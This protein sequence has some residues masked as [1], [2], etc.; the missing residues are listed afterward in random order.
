MSR[1]EHGRAGGRRSGEAYDL[2]VIGGGPAGLAAAVAASRAG[3]TVALIDGG[4]RLGG[5]YYRHPPPGL[6]PSHP[7]TSQHGFARFERLRAALDGRVD[8]LLRHQSWA[9]ERIGGDAS[10]WRDLRGETFAVRCLAGER[11]ETPETVVARRLVIATGAHDLPL[12]FPGWDLPGVMTAGGAQA[13]LKGNLVLAGRRV[14]VAGTGPFL[15]PVAAGLAGAGA[16]VAGVFEANGGL[17]IAPEL[18]RRPGKVAEASRYGYQL[19]RHGTPYRTRHAVIAAHGDRELTHVTVAAIDENWRPRPGRRRTIACDALAVGYGFTPRLDLAVQLGCATGPDGS[20]GVVV[21]VDAGMRTSVPGVYAAGETTGVG[22]ADLAETEGW[23]AGRAVAADL[24]R[25][26]RPAPALSRRRDRQ[27]AFAR[28]LRRAYPIK[29]GWT[30][31]LDDDTLICRCEEVPYARVR[32]ARD[33]GA[34]DARAIKLLARPGMGWCQGR[35][36]GYAVSRLA[37]EDL[38]PPRRLI[39]QPIRLG[40][41]AGLELEPPSSDQRSFDPDTSGLRPPER[42]QTELR[43]PGSEPAQ[44]RHAPPRFDERSH[45]EPRSRPDET[46]SSPAQSPERRQT[47]PQVPGSEPAQGRH[48]PPRFDER[49]HVEPRSRPDETRSSP[50]QSP[51]RRQTEPQVPGSEP[52]QGRHAPPR[53]DERSHVEPRSRP[54]ETRSSPA[55]SPERRQT[56]LRVPGSEPAQGRHAPPRFD[57][58][59]HVEPRSRPDETRSSPAQSPERRQTELR[60]PGSEPAQG[61]HAPP[62]FDER[63]HV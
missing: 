63:S 1:R 55:Q 58:R 4:P 8:V 38:A 42:R 10:S 26:L 35:M 51:E 40:D 45:V 36:C 60:V 43:V 41:L 9:V 7:G 13:L 2:A 20:G 21:R 3:L 16:E 27:E 11:D 17:A 39:S 46:R 50:A 53:F 52:A 5:Q 61:R 59:S 44:G 37:G 14:V 29:D 62:R 25:P 22:G 56:E 33:L 28:A 24:G 32:E 15:L 48:A 47:E 6:R 31:W 18:L 54:D 12:P 34:R 57:E 30:A 23:L 19:A 49:S